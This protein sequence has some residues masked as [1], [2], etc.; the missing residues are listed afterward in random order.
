MTPKKLSSILIVSAIFFGVTLA[1]ATTYKTTLTLSV[2]NARSSYDEAYVL[3]IPADTPITASGWK[4]L[5]VIKASHATDSRDA[6]DPDKKL[7]VT[8]TSSNDFKLK[9]SGIDDT[10]SYSAMSGDNAESAVEATTFEFTAA[11]INKSGGTSKPIGVNVT[12]Y[13]NLSAGDYVDEII[14]NVAVENAVSAPTVG[15]TWT[16]GTYNNE[17]ITWRVLAVDETN[18][19]ALLVTKNAVA[20]MAYQSAGESNNWSTS[21]VKTWL[22][23][24]FI[25]SFTNDEKAK[26]LKVSISDG[27]NSDSSTIINSSGSDT[28]FLL[29]AADAKNTAYFADD[30]ARI[31]QN[32]GEAS[33][34]WL[35]S[36]GDDDDGAAVVYVNGAVLDFGSDV[37]YYYGIRPAF[38]LSY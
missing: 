1:K 9:A 13:S 5:G 33:Y 38:W 15:E 37:E 29:S 25:A 18:K 3:D 32:D 30:N 14:Y 24:T 31:C 11:E 12:D 17:A 21:D 27:D 36:P 19:R 2:A 7:V 6:F 8:I 34:W 28:V 22:N 16:F 4:S 10:V 26:M 35:R 20:I 23:S